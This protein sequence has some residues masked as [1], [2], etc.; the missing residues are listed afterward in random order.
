MSRADRFRL[1]FRYAGRQKGHLVVLIALTFLPAAMAALQPLPLKFFIDNALGGEPVT[2]VAGSM[3]STLGV[4]DGARSLVVAAAIAATVIAIAAFVVSYLVGL[5]WEWVGERMVRDVSRDLFDHLQ[6]LSP[7]FHSRT[8]AG[9]TLSLVTTD[10]SA[11]YTAISAVLVS[12]A[13][14]VFTMLTVGLSAWYLNP[15]LTVVLLASTPILVVVSRRLS[16]RLKKAATRSRRERVAVVSFVTQI[17]HALPVVQAFTAEAQNMHTFRSITDRNVEASRRTVSLQAAADSVTAVV[18][19]GSAA[20]ILVVGGNGVLHGTVTV[21]D[22]VVF[23]AYSRVLDRQF[24]GLLGVGRQLR[25]AEVG[26]DRM[27]AVLTCEDRVSDPPLPLLLP[28]GSGGLSV[29]WDAVTF[30]YEL[31]RPVLNDVSLTV[32]PGE[33][34]AILGPTGAGKST[35]V[36][37]AS[38]LFDPWAGRVLLGGVD[39]RDATVADVRARVSV[40]RQEPLILPVSVADN[41]A[42]ARPGASRTEIERACRNALADEFIEALP[43]GY[44]TILA[45]HGSSLSGGQRQRLAIARAYL[46]DAPVLVLDEPTSALDTESEALFVRSLQE[47]SQGR[48]VLVIA[49]RLS[50]VRRA[51]RAVVLDGGRIVEEGIQ[52]E[53]VRQDGVYARFHRLQMIGAS[54]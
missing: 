5:Y 17:V 47:V 7:R 31:G 15:G 25:L 8:P 4:S 26:L 49:H 44:D 1:L 14:Q 34:V 32:A 42:I 18:G 24:R 27:H 29:R 52:S 48:T 3:L 6:R 45:E 37:L 10:S 2:G 20:L 46:K 28:A 23:L 21:G 50:T 16:V 36:A 12:P 35:L 53:L 54:P 38:R 13:L 41:V 11:A 19:A 39:V 30:G 9:D 43:E 51:D 40:V 33:T 22:L